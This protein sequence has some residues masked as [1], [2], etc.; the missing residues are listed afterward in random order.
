MVASYVTHMGT[1]PATQ[2][3]A[4]TRNQTGDPLVQRPALNPLSHSSQGS[5]LKIRFKIAKLGITHFYVSKKCHSS[6]Y[7]LSTKYLTVDGRKEERKKGQEGK[8][9]EHN[10]VGWRYR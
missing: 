4:L 1:R 9:W 2:A 8:F 5:K 6:S 3:C 10:R 7:R